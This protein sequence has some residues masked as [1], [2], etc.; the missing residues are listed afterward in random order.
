[1]ANIAIPDFSEILEKVK[2]SLISAFGN[3][4]NFDPST[5]TGQFANNLAADFLELY[6]LIQAAYNSSRIETAQG[7]YLDDL[8]SLLN[9]I[10]KLGERSVCQACVLTGDNDTLIPAGSKAKTTTGIEF[11][12]SEDV[13]IMAGNATVDFL[14][15]N[16]GAFRVEPNQLT[17][18]VDAVSGWTTVN[19]PTSSIVGELVQSDGEFRQSILRQSQSL[20]T[21]FGASVRAAIES[22]EGVRQAYVFV[23]YTNSV[24][25]SPHISPAHTIWPI[26]QYNDRTLDSE[27][28][29]AII[30]RLAPVE[31]YNAADRGTQVNVNVPITNQNINIKWNI[32]VE[33]DLNFKII[34][35]ANSDFNEDNENNIKSEINIYLLENSLISKTI[36]YS[37]L[38]AVIVDAAPTAFVESF[39]MK[40][41]A[42]PTAVDI[43]DITPDFWELLVAGTIE[44]EYGN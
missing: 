9:I 14:S 26:I 17:E 12:S 5:P 16:F 35:I 28:A 20:S 27:I 1:M 42:T 4:I 21:D 25:P 44:F 13:T 10:R 30:K 22:I 32:A 23:N 7:K 43:V 8:A 29:E 6:Q 37:K 31:T 40:K 24:S 19:N 36:F 41:N 18:I 3:D 38:Y 39:Y 2:A 34:I 33:S 11:Y 15:L